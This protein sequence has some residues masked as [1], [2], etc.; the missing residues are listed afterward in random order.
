MPATKKAELKT[1]D[2]IEAFIRPL[3]AGKD[4]EEFWV[5]ATNSRN[6]ALAAECIAKGGIS[7]CAVDPRLIFRFLLLTPRATACVFVHNHPSGDTTASRADVELTRVL[8]NGAKLLCY[9]VMDHLI[10][11]DEAPA[12]SMRCSSPSLFAD[13][14]AA[15]MAA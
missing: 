1:P 4:H 11:A 14:D 12:N 15:L 8:I 7:F 9:R 13:A 5:I 6:Q 2:E 10:F 3:I